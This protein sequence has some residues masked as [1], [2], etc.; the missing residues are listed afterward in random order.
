VENVQKEKRSKKERKTKAAMHL[1]K[2][3]FLSEE[4]GARHEC[5][6][7]RQ[8]AL[9]WYLCSGGCL[10]VGLD[11]NERQGVHRWKD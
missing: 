5:V 8:L 4:W 11:V 1:K 7:T 10:D 2:D 6:A 3:D 9:R